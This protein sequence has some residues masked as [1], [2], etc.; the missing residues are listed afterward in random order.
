MTEQGAGQPYLDLD[1]VAAVLAGLRPT[2]T[3]LGVRAGQLTWRDAQASWPQPILTDRS[4][5][6]EPESLGITLTTDRGNEA[7]V[8]IWRGGWADFDVLAG[9]EVTTN[10]PNLASVTDCVEL[11]ETAVNLISG[12]ASPE[13]PGT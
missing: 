4:R 6:A 11:V 1:R 2:W 8:V 3:A 5:I 7:L 9:G 13:R 10:A 12:G